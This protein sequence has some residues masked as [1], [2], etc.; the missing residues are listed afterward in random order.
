MAKIDIQFWVAHRAL[1]NPD[2][3]TNAHYKQAALAVAAGIA[4]RLAI[5]IPVSLPEEAC[6]ISCMPRN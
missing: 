3:F 1:Q 5:A 2:I 6:E 4:I